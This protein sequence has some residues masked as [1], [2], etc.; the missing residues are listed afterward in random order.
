MHN[1]AT[2]R[3]GPYAE[4]SLGEGGERCLALAGVDTVADGPLV[5][6]LLDLVRLQVC[7]QVPD[8]HSLRGLRTAALRSHF[9]KMVAWMIPLAAA[10][11]CSAF[12]GT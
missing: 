7:W 4:L 12:K 10:G 2:S 3:R 8:A 9:F 6:T 5:P 1:G 11:W